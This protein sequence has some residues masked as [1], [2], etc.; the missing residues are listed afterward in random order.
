MRRVVFSKLK[1]FLLLPLM[2]LHLQSGMVLLH[3]H[4][5]DSWHDEKDPVHQFSSVI[6]KTGL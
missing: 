5:N 1:I 6:N 4:F 3:H 2:L